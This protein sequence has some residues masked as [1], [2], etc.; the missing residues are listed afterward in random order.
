MSHPSEERPVPARP[1]ISIAAIS[2]AIG[3]RAL[4]QSPAAAALFAEGDHLM[5]VG[6]YAEACEK[7]V[8]S[9]R[10]EP[11]AGTLI[12]IGQCREKTQQLASAWSAY[13]EGLARAKDPK[14]RAF[15]AERVA[16]LEPRLSRITISVAAVT[17]LVIARNG[18]VVDP[19]L[20]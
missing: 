18:A 6:K 3:A 12:R 16:A 20:W 19:A 2:L 1:C 5:E 10:I 14:K 17:G 15:A 11:G 13:D 7:L 8:A 9:N 4:A